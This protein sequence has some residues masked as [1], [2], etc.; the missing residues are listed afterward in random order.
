VEWMG[1]KSRGS[2]QTEDAKLPGTR[3][4]I[5]SQSQ[6][7]RLLEMGVRLLRNSIPFAPELSAT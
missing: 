6:C 4:Q 7:T 1:Y 3:R 5:E 2:V